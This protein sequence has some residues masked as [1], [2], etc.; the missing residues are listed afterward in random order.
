MNP[1]HRADR[2]A[3]DP[4][5]SSRS[6]GREQVCL[7]RRRVWQ[8]TVGPGAGTQ[9]PTAR[10]AGA[11]ARTHRF[12]PNAGLAVCHGCVAR[13]SGDPR[14]PRPLAKTTRVVGAATNPALNARVTTADG[15]SSRAT[16]S[17]TAWYRS[18]SI[19]VCCSTR[20]TRICASAMNAWTITPANAATTIPRAQTRTSQRRRRSRRRAA[21][22][23]SRRWRGE[24]PGASTP[25]APTPG[26]DRR[27]IR[28]GAGAAATG[29]T[30][31]VPPRAVAHSTTAG[32]R[33]VP[34]RSV[35]Q[36]Y[37]SGD[38]PTVPVAEREAIDARYSARAQSPTILR[39]DA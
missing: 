10:L 23:T 19:L 16:C 22:S 7:G 35:A 6:T 33:P 27:G 4:A 11:G 1:R 24:T 25:G 36:A 37:D 32:S 9:S 2:N 12:D 15:E 38:E 29:L 34:H 28:C 17:R 30:R 13:A 20:P 21:G 39:T 5:R 3:G 31:A 8:P 18:C 14:S 26:G